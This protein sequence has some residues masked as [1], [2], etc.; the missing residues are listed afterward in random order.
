M[1]LS[2]NWIGDFV[3]LSGLDKR[4]LIQRF[5]LSTAEVEDIIERGADTSGVIVARVASC[6]AHP[7]SKKLHLLKIDTGSKLVDCVCGAPNVREG[8]LVAFATEGGALSATEEDVRSFYF[9]EDSARV[10]LV[11]LDSRS[12][13]ATR[14]EEIRNTIAGLGSADEVAGYI[15]SHTATAPEDVFA[16]VLIGRHS[17]D[18]AYYREMVDCAFELVYGETGEVISITTNDSSN[19]HILYKTVKNDEHF[20][21]NYE[22]IRNVYISDTI[23]RLINEDKAELIDSAEATEFYESINRS[24]ISMK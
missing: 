22:S 21:S 19:Y 11:T 5:T 13:T 20:E 17:L 7:T 4:A 24:Q 1:L 9:G 14:A 18:S 16:G 3:D 10:L 6:E 15:V 2:M 12:Y 8:M 23:G